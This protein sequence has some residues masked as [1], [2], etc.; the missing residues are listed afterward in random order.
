MACPIFVRAPQQ[1]RTF[2]RE[3]VDMKNASALILMLS[4]ACIHAAA[5]DWSLMSVGANGQALLV[6][7]SSVISEGDRKIIWT[8]VV[9]K[10]PAGSPPHDIVRNRLA[11]DCKKRNFQA[12]TISNI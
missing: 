8:M 10:E 5:A 1:K 3:W 11:L 9:L 2:L 6:D 4:V 12:S 7:S